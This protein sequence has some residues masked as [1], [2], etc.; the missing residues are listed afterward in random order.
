M[1]IRTLLALVF[2]F[3]LAGCSQPTLQ[4]ADSNA[5]ATPNLPNP[6]SVYCEQQGYRLEI[7]TASDGSQSGVCIFPDGSQCDEWAYYRRECVPATQGASM[8][9]PASV[10]CE[11]QGYKVEIRTASDGS[12]SGACVFPGGSQCDEWAYFR[13]DCKAPESTPTGSPGTNSQGWE[14]Y[15]N[16]SLGYSFH[17]PAGADITA[18]DDPQ[19]SLSITGSGLGGEYWTVAH[20]SDRLEYRPP[21]GVDLLQ[22][23]ADHYLLGEEQQ[24]DEQ[25]AGTS[26]IHFRHAASPQS[27][28]VD[29]YY[30]ARAGQ[31]YQISIGH[32]GEVEDWELDNRFLQSFQFHEPTSPAANTIP[33]ALPIDPAAYQGWST[34]TNPDYGFSL[35]LPD[36][37]IVEEPGYGDP[38]LVGHELNIHSVID[39]SPNNIRLTFRQ[40]GDDT[41]LWP[42]GVG[43]GEFIQQGT[44]VIGDQPVLRVL[45]V[46]RSGAVSDIWYH[47]SDGQPNISI[48]ELEFG[49]IFSTPGHCEPGNNLGGDAQLIGEMIIASLT[50]P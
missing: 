44:L 43:E 37:W 15:T 41:W 7:L 48:G 11:Q 29:T 32:G 19:K 50:V 10:F 33:T 1:K 46:C 26:A 12:Q 14:I 36:G 5:S 30:F 31:L 39:A 13:G 38:L 20:P 9:N 16:D 21:N 18:N 23:L 34:Y 49:I 2:F 47:Q 4:P 35:K 40:R 27:Y 42:T 28:A 6:A 22:W 25:I 8:P 3:I 24:P 17:Y 45:L